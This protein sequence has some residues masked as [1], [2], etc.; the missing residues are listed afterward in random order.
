M[1]RLLNNVKQIGGGGGGRV[2]LMEAS[3]IGLFDTSRR[4]INVSAVCVCVCE[5]HYEIIR[6][7]LNYDY[8]HYVRFLCNRSLFFV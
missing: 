3:S 4:C 8:F 7:N 1:L 2:N 6:L 5:I